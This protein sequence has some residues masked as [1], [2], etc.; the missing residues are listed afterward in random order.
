MI[1]SGNTLY[2]TTVWGGIGN[3]G[4]IFSVNTDSTGFAP[5]HSFNGSDGSFVHAE[6]V[7]SGNTLYGTAI[8]G[9]VSDFGTVFAINTDGTGFTNLYNFTGGSDG[10]NPA[11]DGLLLSGNTFYGTTGGGSFSYGTVFSFSFAP[12]LTIIL[13]G[14]NV[15]LSWPNSLDGFGYA[16]FTLQSTANLSP[17]A[18]NTVFPAPVVM[19][20]LNIVTNAISGT[21]QFYRL[22][23]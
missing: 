16:G 13:S 15:I 14:T 21:Q 3:N 23:Q 5:L 2:G 7:L 19:N 17:A 11:E 6:L 10:G 8:A 1:L 22:S 12:Q 9:G 4:A 20:G 18:W